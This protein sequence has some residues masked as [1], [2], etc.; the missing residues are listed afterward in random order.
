MSAS[1]EAKTCSRLRERGAAQ[2]RRSRPRAR[3]VADTRL[4]LYALRL[5]E[6]ADDARL[7]AADTQMR[8]ISGTAQGGRWQ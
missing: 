1:G 4:R 2:D 6:A 5:N 8:Q 3:A 7:R